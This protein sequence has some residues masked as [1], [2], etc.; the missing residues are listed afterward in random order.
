[1]QSNCPACSG[2]GKVI[3]SPCKTCHG[4]GRQRKEKTISVKIPA[5]INNGNRIKLT[6]MGEKS[7]PGGK[8][9]DLYVE[10]SIASDTV[11]KR[12]GQDVHSTGVVDFVTATLGG[13]I[14]IPSLDGLKEIKISPGFQGGT[15]MRI[16]GGGVV[17]IN[18]THKG[19]LYCEIRIET[20]TNLSEEQKEILK[21]FAKSCG[22]EH[23]PENE[24]FMDKIKSYF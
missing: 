20:P 5:G 3:N 13:A 19:D 4:V 8:D 10:I 23:H 18:G 22:A 1:V 6:G 15:K 16:T 12:Q 14:K 7:G 9:G 2:K 11:F 21:Q 17:A 24:S